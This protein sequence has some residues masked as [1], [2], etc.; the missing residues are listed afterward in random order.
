M[1]EN[2]S[3]KGK[4]YAFI[5][6]ALLS[7]GSYLDYTVVNVA[8][9]TIQQDLK[10]DLTTL[11]WVMN[12]Y[13]LAL[14]IFAIIMG[15]CGD[16][17]GRR[18]VFYIGAIIFGIASFIA[19][20]ASSIKILI[21]GR[22]LQGIGAAII[23]PLGPSLLPQVFPKNEH[24]KSIGLLGSLGGIALALGPVVGGI[25]VSYWGWPWIF[26][27]NIPIIIVGFLFCYRAVPESKQ[28]SST[29]ALDWLGALLLA[30]SVGGIVLALFH[31]QSVGWLNLITIIYFIIGIVATIILIKVESQKQNPL[32][33]FKDFSNFLFY[34][35]AM[36]C[37][38]A[39]VLSAVTLFFDPLYLQIIRDQSPQIAGIVLFSIPIAVFLLAVIVGWI[40]NQLGIIYSIITGF[41][42]A[43]LAAFMQVFFTIDISL[44]YI[45]FAFIC[46]GCMW[47]LGNTLPI[48]AAQIALGT[49]RASVA[50]G[51]V[52]TMFNIGGALG[53][54]IS[55]IVYNA[56]ANHML[57]KLITMT[58]TISMDEAIK[59]NHFIVSPGSIQGVS[60]S[61]SVKVYLI[62]SF[63]NGFT[64]VM[65]FLTLISLF[66]LLS[67]F[68][69]KYKEFWF[70][71]HT[72]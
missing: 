63:M 12:I 2:N 56:M 23:F 8:L 41:I 42:L 1:N 14:C 62:K 32:I 44:G 61:H 21:F 57:Q 29:A 17:Y 10:A 53:L 20:A 71:R 18:R 7:F 25:I 9:P 40:V 6:I 60:I 50:T 45:I 72:K 64:S 27:I 24:A 54:A 47:A 35:G 30:C 68:L 22:L 70:V 13:F 36:L 4:W 46:L 37:F 26:Y 49:E 65:W 66:I 19:G 51:T 15:R 11:Q 48:I 69:K 31:G 38:I 43:V 67:I 59:L 58:T 55:V 16:L 52:V 28:V 39:G 33:D 5:G 34:S 3:Y